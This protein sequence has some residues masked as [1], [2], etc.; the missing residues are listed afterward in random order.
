MKNIL[1]K[2]FKYDESDI[3]LLTDFNEEP[4][5]SNIMS[6]LKYLVD[7]SSNLDEIYIHYS[8]HGKQINDINGDEI[9]GKDECILPIDFKNSGVII[10]SVIKLNAG[11][12]K[13]NDIIFL[14]IICL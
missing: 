6:K 4:T 10:V 12:I 14:F 13:M 7:L 1:I 11:I 8:G 5:Y 3:L 2:I 9:D